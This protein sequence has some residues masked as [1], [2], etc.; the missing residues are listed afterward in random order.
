LKSETLIFGNGDVVSVADAFNKKIE[1]GCD[2]VMV[3][4][5]IFGKPWFF[6]EKNPDL[7]TRLKILIEHIEIFDKVIEYKNFAVM[8]KHFKAYVEGFDGAKDLRVKLM[9]VN[10]AKEAIK[11]IKD[12]IKSI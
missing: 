9:A 10:S 11:I 2:G 8:K 12:F 6:S 4:R 7:K 5:G 1:T 3:G